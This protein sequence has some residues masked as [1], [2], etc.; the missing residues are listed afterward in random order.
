MKNRIIQNTFVGVISLLFITMVF[1]PTTCGNTIVRITTDFDATAYSRIQQYSVGNPP[2]EQW[3]STHGGELNDQG[4]YVEQT[5]D[6]GYII[7]GQTGSYGAGG[8]DIWLIK[9]NA[10]G[11][12]QW[13]STFGGSN[14]DFGSSVLQQTNGG[15]IIIGRTYSY[16]AGNGD[17]WLIKTD[18]TGHMTWNTTFGGTGVE[19]GSFLQ[20]TNDGG[21][22]LVGGTSSYGA[23][24]TNVWLIKTD[25]NG[26]ETWNKTYG[27][28]N[29]ET[30]ATSVQQTSDGG[31]IVTGSITTDIYPTLN[32]WLLKT[33]ANGNKLW[34]KN[35]GDEFDEW[36]SCVQQTSDNG[37]IIAANK[38]NDF[39][40]IKTNSLGSEEW[41]KKYDHSQSPDRCSS[42]QETIEGGFI[43]TGYAYVSSLGDRI[44]LVKTDA[45]GNM[46][47]DMTI[48][49]MSAHGY[50][51]HQTH[52]NGFIVVGEIS[53]NLMDV[54]LIKI[55]PEGLPYAPTISGEINGK[56]GT[57]YEYTFNAVD[58][59]EDNVYYSIDWGDGTT[60]NWIGPYPSGQ[61]IKVNHTWVKKGIYSITAKAKDT[62]DR[63]GPKGTL[64]VTMP[65]NIP[66]L[67]VISQ[68]FQEPHSLMVLIASILL[69]HS[70][71]FRMHH[72][73]SSGM[74]R[75]LDTIKHR[76][77]FSCE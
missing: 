63:I 23:G 52:D 26:K 60:G 14:N 37:Y 59:N 8:Y 46:Q 27:V 29:K 40:L 34:E 18:S 56:K 54:Y 42:V 13:N 30:S 57:A 67:S 20:Q 53:G 73:S 16:G 70:S 58:P 28:T 43:L 15:Y 21:Y 49:T 41:N 48:G 11:V 25:A 65:Q 51:G 31:Y 44:W 9:T 35:F 22:I 47:W 12:E 5:I 4:K 64:K 69:K 10:Q 55:E 33:D 76:V 66:S 39:W 36:G 45:D 61:D 77:E 32:V 62:N 24:H 1:H 6:E 75:V 3:N 2:L 71:N 68:R 72:L 7:V 38:E 17:I 74:L 50:C 19:Y